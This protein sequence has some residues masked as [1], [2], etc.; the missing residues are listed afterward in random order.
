MRYYLLICSI[1]NVFG[2]KNVPHFSDVF[3]YTFIVA[4]QYTCGLTL[5]KSNPHAV[6]IVRIIFS[7]LYFFPTN[8]AISCSKTI[9]RGELAIFCFAIG[10]LVVFFMCE[11][12]EKNP[13]FNFLSQNISLE[14]NF[15][16]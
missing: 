3:V 8:N 2:K 11:T 6:K 16:K 7:I 10:V 1:A 13:Q 5:D 4:K 15:F 9:N 12:S 14:G